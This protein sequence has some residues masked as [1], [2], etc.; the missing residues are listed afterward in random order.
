MVFFTGLLIFILPLSSFTNQSKIVL[1]DIESGPNSPATTP[2]N[3]EVDV[4]SIYSDSFTNVPNTNF[5]AN[6]NQKTKV[7]EVSI[8]G[9]KIL[10]YT[11][12]NYQGIEFGSSVVASSME[13]LHIDIWTADASAMNVEI[14][15]PGPN[16]SSYSLSITNSSWVSYDI[17]LNS[18]NG[19]VDVSD[20]FQAAFNDAG[21]GGSPTIYID[22]IYFYKSETS[23][24]SDAFLT[25][26]KVNSESIEGFSSSK[27]D[28]TYNV[29]ASL[30]TPPSIEVTK[31]NPDAF[32]LVKQAESISGQATA[33]VTS[34]DSS[35]VNTYTVQF[36]PIL[37]PDVASPTP[38]ARSTNDVISI[39][40]SVYENIKNVNFN[41]NWGQSTKVSNF[42]VENEQ[43]FKYSNFNYQ[44]IELN[45]R[46]NVSDMDYLH[47]DIWTADAKAINL[48]V[49]SPGPAET[50]VSLEIEKG[51]WKS[52]DIPLSSY[53]SIV[54]LSEVFQFKFDDNG[55]GDKPTFYLDNLY[56][57]KG[58]VSDSDD[59]TLKKIQLDSELLDDFDPSI[60][61]Y[62]IFLPSNTNKIPKVSVVPTDSNATVT[63]EPASTL[64]G[65]TTI[66][67]LA[68]NDLTNKTYTIE[69]ELFEEDSDP[70]LN[71]INVNGN[72]LTSFNPLKK[73]YI[74]NLGDLQENP[75]VSATAN[76]SDATVTYIDR[77][78]YTY[79]KVISADY[80]D[81][82][83]YSIFF[84]PEHL[85][86]WDDF[87]NSNLDLNYWS[88]EIG[89]GCNQGE[90]LCGWGNQ[91]LQFYSEENVSIEAVPGEEGNNAL[92]ITA[93]EQEDGFTSGRLTTKDNIHFK[94][95]IIEVRI[96]VPEVETG[97][98]PAA[99]FL[100]GNH[101]EV[102]WP[103]S[104]E[105][106]LMEMGQKK[107]TRTQQGFPNSTANQYVGSNVIWYAEAACVPGN[108]TCAAGI[109][110]DVNYNRPYVSNTELNNRFQI[111]RLYWSEK[112]IKFTVQDNG[113]EYDLYASPFGTTINEVRSAFNQD[114]FMIL[115]LAVGG[116][117]TDA[118]STN[119]VTA[120]F[121][122]KMYID[123]VRHYKYNGEGSVLID[124]KIITPI[125]PNKESYEHPKSLKLYQNY[126]NP[127]NPIT[128]IEFEL[129]KVSTVQIVVRDLLG[130]LIS[131]Q[132]ME[133]LNSGVHTVKFDA[134]NLSSGLYLYSI[135][136]NGQMMDTKKMI[137]LK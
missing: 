90:N 117:F 24:E 62:E 108:E 44:G 131:D 26:I 91:E 98:W 1:Y 12:F 20:I 35:V 96:K 106:D 46:I 29:S 133:S 37:E 21:S 95:G 120:P 85:I 15:S 137:L 93:K 136:I 64:P 66:N 116:N 121:P 18:F 45:Q 87:S 125:E 78:Q 80:S 57:Y 68:E 47:V 104:G 75:Q 109:A 31:S 74:Y 50:P 30:T 4:I 99:W 32:L 3:K 51:K 113:T 126:P 69:F 73:N 8:D 59:A 76:N 36:V 42:S 53:S 58:D 115:N 7:S 71:S 5:Y 134:S 22:N 63:I 27:L 86:W 6:W 118:L 122:A 103:K 65:V 11:D 28:Y 72:S 101:A 48:F 2:Q 105:I 88:Y 124:G 55:R 100:G 110:G 23:P 13:Y 94:Y 127:F 10:K 102:G 132:K 114:F 40:S 25:D 128:S 34:L 39:Y 84:R 41:P 70:S 67:V 82:T 112:H 17:P 19:S 43:T 92:V 83:M 52:Y 49:I 61:S 111:Y 107:A 60:V 54:D 130:R 9:N 79:I 97:L 33:E 77:D 16:I 135:I 89:N 14:I 38:P 123:Y 129:H 56:F 81:S 119:Q